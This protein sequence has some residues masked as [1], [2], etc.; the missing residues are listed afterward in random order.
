MLVFKQLITAFKASCNCCSIVN[1][2][3][4]INI[5][6]LKVVREKPK[7]AIFHP[8]GSFT[9][10]FENLVAKNINNVAMR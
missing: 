9:L 6:N 5:I 7:L 3:N 10:A 2:I 8:Y 4:I 1:I